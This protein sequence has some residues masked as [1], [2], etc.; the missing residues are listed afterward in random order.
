MPHADAAPG[1]A[2]HVLPWQQP[3]GQLCGSQMQAAP[4]QRWPVPHAAPPPHEHPPLTQESPAVEQLVHASPST[5]QAAR[6]VP[7]AQIPPLQQPSWHAVYPAEP[8]NVW[9]LPAAV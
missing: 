5:P 1:V 9:H 2:R 8:Q 4:E 3:L 7:V 6:A